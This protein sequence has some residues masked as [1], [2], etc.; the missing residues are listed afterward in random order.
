MTDRPKPPFPPQK[1]TMPG[2]T[3]KMHRSGGCPS[4]ALRCIGSQLALNGRGKHSSNITAVEGKPA[5]PSRC[6]NFSV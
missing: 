6:R 2:L 3:R 5:A 4:V 1:Q